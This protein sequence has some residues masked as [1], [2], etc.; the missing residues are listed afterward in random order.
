MI[1]QQLEICIFSYLA[2]EL[3]TGDACVVG[4]EHYADFREQLLPWSECESLVAQ[5]CQDL[6]F[7]HTPE[8]FIADLKT[9]LTEVALA[10]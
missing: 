8:H 3:K 2:T 5:Y 4:S 6:G 7:S 10:K 1:R 9:K